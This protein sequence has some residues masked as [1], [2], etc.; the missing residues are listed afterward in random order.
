M[1]QQQQHQPHLANTSTQQPSTQDP[2]VHMEPT[3]GTSFQ[4][5]RGNTL[6]DFM[7]PEVLIEA[8][9]QR[10][11]EMHRDFGEY[12]EKAS[13]QIDM[14]A[15]SLQYVF[16]S[17]KCRLKKFN[18]QSEIPL[19][20]SIQRQRFYISSHMR[21]P[22][23]TLGHRHRGRSPVRRPRIDLA[24]TR[25]TGWLSDSIKYIWSFQIFV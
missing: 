5:N 19:M 16:H 22:K 13:V 25:G 9:L 15:A 6:M 17:S 14:M 4:F 24:R 12:R 7:M 8:E 21:N 20:T 18:C 23:E 3:I 11:F 10:H 1:S 2:D